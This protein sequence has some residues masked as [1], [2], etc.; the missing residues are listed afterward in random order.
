MALAV[1]GDL[2]AVELVAAFALLFLLAVV[3]A[4]VV[5]GVFGVFE[6]RVVMGVSSLHN[7]S[8]IG[9]QKATKHY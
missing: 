3:F 9:S 4:P 2:R 1:A 8:C 7:K 6:V 5:L